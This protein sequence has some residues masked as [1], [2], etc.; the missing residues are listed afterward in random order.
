MKNG[1]VLAFSCGFADNSEI[2]YNGYPE[3]AAAA[4][5]SRE[6]EQW[7]TVLPG[8]VYEEPESGLLYQHTSVEFRTYSWIEENFGIESLAAEQYLMISEDGEKYANVEMEGENL[9]LSVW[10][11]DNLKEPVIRVPL[12]NHKAY[13]ID[14]R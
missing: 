5:W 11:A 6:E 12:K 14:T 1:N 4:L 8:F 13:Y 10:E 7:L 2:T 3:T 9:Y